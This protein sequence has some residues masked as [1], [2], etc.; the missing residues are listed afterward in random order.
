MAR[1]R[2]RARELALQALYQWDVVPSFRETEARAFIDERARDPE[3]AE[4]AHGLVNGVVQDRDRIDGLIASRAA[5]W[6]VGR[7]AVTDRNL[8]RMA[9]L[10]MGP[11]SDVPP[12]VV[13][14]EAVELAKQFGSDKSGAFVNG[15]LDPIAMELAPGMKRDGRPKR[16]KKE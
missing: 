10:E 6:D 15:I 9:V 8:L 5:R 4:Y 2:T 11:G 1:K 7:M 14:N 3:I 12:R 16:T 13:I